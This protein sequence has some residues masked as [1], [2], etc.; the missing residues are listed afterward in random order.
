[1][2]IERVN[3]PD[4]RSVKMS[5]WYD[6]VRLFSGAGAKC[7][8]G[9]GV[10][11]NLDWSWRIGLTEEFVVLGLR[12][13]FD[14]PPT[15]TALGLAVVILALGGRVEWR[16]PLERLLT[17]PGWRPGGGSQNAPIIKPD[18]QLLL[19]LAG[20]DLEATKSF[21]LVLTGLRRM[22]P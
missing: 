19:T 11:W 9:G 17:E 15:G 13:Y 14:M 2:S 22:T 20:V 16:A 18:G 5:N 1:M 4:G 3:L 21:C 10:L 12:A 7:T 8:P 6:D